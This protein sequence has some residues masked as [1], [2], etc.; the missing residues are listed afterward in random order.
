MGSGY[1][2]LFLAGSPFGSFSGICSRLWD[3]RY[4][5]SCGAMRLFALQIPGR[6][7]FSLPGFTSI[8]PK[9]YNLK[10]IT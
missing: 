5:P 1:P 8:K 7:I 10:L 2:L 6:E 4:Y 3:I 9:T